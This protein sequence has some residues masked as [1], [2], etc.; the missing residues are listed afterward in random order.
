MSTKRERYKCFT[1]NRLLVV[2]FMLLG[3]WWDI[4]LPADIFSTMGTLCWLYMPMLSRW[5]LRMLDVVKKYKR[6]KK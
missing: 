5:E 4:S 6:G 2:G 1:V 3:I